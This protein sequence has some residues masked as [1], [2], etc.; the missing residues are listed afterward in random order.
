MKDIEKVL[1]D[2]QL[3]NNRQHGLDIYVVIDDHDRDDPPA[4]ARRSMTNELAARTPT[5]NFGQRVLNHEIE[6]AVEGWRKRNE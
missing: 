5:R 6:K 4:V 1:R 2:I 3:K